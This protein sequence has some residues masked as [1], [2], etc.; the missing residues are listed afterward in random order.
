[1]RR[2][3]SMNAN[4][5]YAMRRKTVAQIDGDEIPSGLSARTSRR[6]GHSRETPPFIALREAAATRAS[7]GRR[8]DYNVGEWNEAVVTFECAHHRGRNRVGS[9]HVPAV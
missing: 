9:G 6:R 7:V 1:M 3:R 5:A 2:T 4:A 8:V